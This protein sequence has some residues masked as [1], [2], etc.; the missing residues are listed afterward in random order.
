ML[1][2]AG[3][4]KLGEKLTKAYLGKK[5]T[6]DIQGRAFRLVNFLKGHVLLG[7]NFWN[8]VFL[9]P[10]QSMGLV[11]ADLC[12]YITWPNLLASWALLLVEINDINK[13]VSIIPVY[14]CIHCRGEQILDTTGCS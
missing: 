12:S 3:I 11:S 4:A 14:T 1:V 7:S 5:S 9:S 2:L 6:Y 8:S 13:Q 10:W